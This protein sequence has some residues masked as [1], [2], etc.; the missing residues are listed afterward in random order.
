MKL[1]AIALVTV[2]LILAAACGGQ[3]GATPSASGGPAAGAITGN[4]TLW[5]AYGTGGSEEQA[6]NQL[7]DKIRTAN[8]NAKITVIQVPFDQDFNKLQ[9]EEAAGGGAGL[10][11]S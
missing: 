5:H 1:R 4:I 10:F 11:L 7:I 9:N 8:P 6:L 3:G 2:A